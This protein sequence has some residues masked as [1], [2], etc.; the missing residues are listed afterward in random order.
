M[1]NVFEDFEKMVIIW[2]DNAILRSG[3][4]DV[5]I[6]LTGDR[7]RKDDKGPEVRQLT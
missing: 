1:Y 2:D 3:D 5:I 4:P 7:H 6:A